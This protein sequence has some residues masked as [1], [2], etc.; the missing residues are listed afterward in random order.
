MPIP[1]PLSGLIGNPQLMPTVLSTL[2]INPEHHPRGQPHL[3][4][5]SGLVRL[6][7]R[8]FVVADDELH[9][10]IF[11]DFTEASPMTGE[12]NLLRLLDGK[13][14]NTMEK[15]KE[16]KPDLETLALLPPLPGFETGAL[17]ALGS[18]SKPQRQTGVLIAL[19]ELGTPSGSMATMDLTALYAP[20]RSEFAD[21]NIEGAFLSHDHS[22]FILLQ[23]GNKTDARSACIRYDWRALAAWLV[24]HHT[25]PP[26]A[27]SV[28]IITLGS[29]DGVPLSFTDG[30]ALPNNQPGNHSGAWVFSAVAEATNDSV[31]DGACVASAVG[32]ISQE[33]K[34]LSIALLHNAPKIEGIAVKA[35]GKDWLLTMV[36]DP[37]NPELAAQVLQVLL[38]VV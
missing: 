27:K 17:L 10:G 8:L 7:K 15:R 19:D 30:A 14:P 3:S 16:A 38:K 13:L 32:I 24:G 4:A 36:T 9:L 23:R 22:E 2:R 1:K 12:G 26:A 28:Q 31:Q 6:G 21:L 18:G 25:A 34:V 37:D 33:G 11:D 20:L 35:A 29:V 5:A